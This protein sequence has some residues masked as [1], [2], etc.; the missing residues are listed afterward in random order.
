M[1]NG[2]QKTPPSGATSS[3]RGRIESSESQGTKYLQIKFNDPDFNGEFNYPTNTIIT[4]KYTYLN[5]IPI[6]LLEQF[7]RIANTYFL[8]TT[9]LCF[10][11]EIAPFS[12]V[13]SIMP[14]LLILLCTGVKD[15]VEDRKR[16]KQ[17]DHHNSIPVDRISKKGRVEVTRSSELRVGD[18]IKIKQDQ[19]IPADCV[20][21]K[22]PPK[23]DGTCRMNT[24][25]LDGENAPKIRKAL[26]RTQDMRLRD[27]AKVD[28]TIE[29]KE[30]DKQLRGFNGRLIMTGFP[31]TPVD[32][33]HF[34]FRAAFLANTRHVYALVLYVGTD[35]TL[36]LNRSGTPWKFSTFEHNL[37]Y[38][39]AFLLLTNL[40]LCVLL[41]IFAAGTFVY[42]EPFPL[43]NV[44]DN[45]YQFWLDLGTWYILFSFMIPI[46]LYVTVE[47]VKIFEALFMQHDFDCSVWEIPYNHMLE[48]EKGMNPVKKAGQ[49]GNFL[50]ESNLSPE[51]NISM[52]DRAVRKGMQV[53][54]SALNEELGQVQYIFTDKTGTLTQ[55][56]ME[57][58]KISVNG[59]K[60]L[61]DLGT[62][63]EINMEPNF[64][65]LSKEISN[66]C[67]EIKS[68]GLPDTPLYHL[69]VNL[70]V[71]SE[72]LIT[73]HGSSLRY[74]S[75]SPDEV[76]FA[77]ALDVVGV[78]LMNRDS[79][80]NVTIEFQGEA[81]E[82]R[83][84]AVLEFQSKRLRMTVI[85]EDKNGRVYAY[86]KGADTK[87]L[88]HPVKGGGMIGSGQRD[89]IKKTVKH[90]EEFASAGSR[91]L[92]AG[93]R[94]LSV[95]QFRKFWDVYK[96]ASNAIDQREDRIEEAFV[97]IE[98]DMKLIGCTAVEDQI[99]DGVLEVVQDLK[100]ASIKV[101]MLTGDKM[102][103]AVTIGQLSGIIGG[104]KVVW[105]EPP[106]K[107]IPSLEEQY[108]NVLEELRAASSVRSSL[109]INGEMLEQ[110]IANYES[111]FKEVFDKVDSIICNRAAP[112]QKACVV[113]WAMTTYSGV[114]LAIGDGANDVSMIQASNVGVGI[115]GKEG[116][117]AALASDFIIYRFSFLKKLLFVHGHYNY[118][119][120]SKVVLIC[121]YKNL[122]CILPLCWYGMYS[123][124]TG[125]SFFEA[126]M[127][128]MFNI[129]FTSLPPFVCGLL[130]KDAPQICL[131]SYPEAY[132]DL[133]QVHPPFSL[134][135]FIGWCFDAIAQS[136]LYFFYCWCIVGSNRNVWSSDGKTAGLF[137]FGT[138]L[139]TYEIVAINIKMLSMCQFWNVFMILSP[140]IGI[141]SYILL[142]LV[143]E[144]VCWF[145]WDGCYVF[146]WVIS[147]PLF[148]LA[149]IPF[150]ILTTL[151]GVLQEAIRKH[152]DPNLGDILTEAFTS[153][154]HLDPKGNLRPLKEICKQYQ[155]EKF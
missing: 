78:H 25:S 142:W 128:S 67:E 125:Q 82:Y 148:W 101:M 11:E 153:K 105:I 22:G 147:K 63:G 21:L 77:E 75:P 122:A 151:P 8:L 99:Q 124:A 26:S 115:M 146:S 126:T 2:E 136:L 5:F 149:L 145:T 102:E 135:I 36:M 108:A 28:A 43:L 34:L 41:A 119:R 80:N 59:V 70:L 65:K 154:Y 47:L 72:T 9:V 64:F 112:A 51:H 118:L 83:T 90:M 13:T 69:S 88:P 23:G 143:Y 46:S 106:N 29:C 31:T 110:S 86:T 19:E 16:H 113:R 120:T 121:I 76:A 14:L 27:L 133:S 32:D 6:N 68:N 87:M 20:V 139:Y 93:Y 1:I 141:I 92:V 61:H 131:M 117:Q 18:I 138:M 7:R 55:N 89:L 114:C 103:T 17:D 98:T 134:S 58:S 66:M 73:R 107:N 12:P 94:E 111:E 56:K 123:H 144:Q 84:L 24:S 140:I 35:T 85:S 3:M 33:S 132:H 95:K 91:I 137:G 130:E 38:C 50:S 40:L 15:W 97:P 37:N 48:K 42:P 81:Y 4:S 104:E 100:R 57:L 45:M 152:R 116:T 60:L 54:A 10:I 150:I 44:G 62:A 52:L 71:C 74:L 129:F 49:L 127:L 30:N 96:L 79:K 53:R 109:V 155:K 39:V